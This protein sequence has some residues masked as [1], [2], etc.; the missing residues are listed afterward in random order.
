VL[1]VGDAGMGPDSAQGECG[2]SQHS[3]DEPGKAACILEVIG[4]K[5]FPDRK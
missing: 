3:D 4:H 1:G 2:K 5:K